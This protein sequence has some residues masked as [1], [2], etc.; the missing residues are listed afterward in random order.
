MNVGYSL[1]YMCKHA[2]LFKKL[3]SVWLQFR[4]K[5]STLSFPNALI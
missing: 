4:A 1:E 2:Q 5:K 3:S